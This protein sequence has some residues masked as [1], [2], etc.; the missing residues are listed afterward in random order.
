MRSDSIASEEISGSSA[1]EMEQ[2]PNTSK[3]N[4]RII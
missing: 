3:K 2:I 1:T 4:N